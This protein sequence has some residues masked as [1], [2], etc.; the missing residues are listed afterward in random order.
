MSTGVETLEVVE[1][2]LWSLLSTDAVLAG[3]V[4]N[5]IVGTLAEGEVDAP[6]VVWTMASARD[7]RGVGQVRQQVDCIYN[8]KGVTTGASWSAVV[9]IAKRLDAL[10]TTAG[11]VSTVGGDLVCTREGVIQYAE[12]LE[13]SQFRHLGAS[14]R[15]R[16]NSHQG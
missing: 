5:R 10:L 14:W 9:P 6:Y 2:W 7:V 3:L 4:A 12:V 8:I 15:I 16:A 13:G 1:P 11:T